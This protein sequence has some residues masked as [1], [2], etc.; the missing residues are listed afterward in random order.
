[1]ITTKRPRLSLL[2]R[3]AFNSLNNR[4]PQTLANPS[5]PLGSNP[6]VRVCD[7]L[8]RSWQDPGLLVCR[9]MTDTLRGAERRSVN[10]WYLLKT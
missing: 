2:G 3:K 9:A 10:R 7:E 8:A 5:Y 1:M 4:F 6:Q